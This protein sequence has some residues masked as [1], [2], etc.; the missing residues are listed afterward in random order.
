M[1]EMNE[2][3]LDVQVDGGKHYI[4]RESCETIQTNGSKASDNENEADE[5]MVT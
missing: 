1:P 2:D 3:Q 4:S 5:K